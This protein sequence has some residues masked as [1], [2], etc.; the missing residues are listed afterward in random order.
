MNSTN[1]NQVVTGNVLLPGI[2]RNGQS[3][4]NIF[5]FFFI[6][7]FQVIFLLKIKKFN[8]NNRFKRDFLHLKKKTIYNQL[9]YNFLIIEIKNK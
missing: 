2:L 8:L 1:I 3:K 7:L 9:I 5:R 4:L 6:L